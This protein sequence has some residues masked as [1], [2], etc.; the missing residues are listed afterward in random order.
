MNRF[1]D[2]AL[3][4][5]AKLV[6]RPGQLVLLVARLGFK[7]KAIDPTMLTRDVKEK[8]HLFARMAMAV[9]RG[10][11]RHLSIKSATIIVAGIVY[12]INPLDLIPDFV[13]GLGFTDDITVLL[14]VYKSVGQE[15]NRFLLWEKV[16]HSSAGIDVN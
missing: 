2:L 12:F 6:G 9:G 14:W 10:H 15:V 5:A 13:A 1:V 11:Y 16:N 8:L 3:Q 7:M 4:K